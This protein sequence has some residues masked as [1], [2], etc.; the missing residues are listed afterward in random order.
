MG[1]T[2]RLRLSLAPALAGAVL[3]AFALRAEL[4]AGP[5]IDPDG[6]VQVDPN[7]LVDPEAAATPSATP[8]PTPTPTPST[9]TDGGGGGATPTPSPTP[10][11]K[12]APKCKRKLRTSAML[13]VGGSVGGQPGSSPPDSHW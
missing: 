8:E 5:G 6:P 3:L 11:K 4:R 7:Q 13:A 2:H 10:K 1:V 9:P 12:S